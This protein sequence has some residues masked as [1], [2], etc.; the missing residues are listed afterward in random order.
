MNTSQQSE[1]KFKSSFIDQNNLDWRFYESYNTSVDFNSV[2]N[3]FK[4][5]SNYK[6]N[7]DI[8]LR[9]TKLVKNVSKIL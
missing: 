5:L 2:E 1:R 3:V 8:I 7:K 4:C 9:R 6:L